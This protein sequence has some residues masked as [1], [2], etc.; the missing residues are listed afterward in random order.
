MQAPRVFAARSPMIGL[1]SSGVLLAAMAVLAVVAIRHKPLHTLGQWL[2]LLMILA[3]AAV[4]VFFAAIL[5][6]MTYLIDDSNLIFR[7]GPFR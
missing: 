1:I 5:P 7:C 6:T 3:F 4:V 2:P